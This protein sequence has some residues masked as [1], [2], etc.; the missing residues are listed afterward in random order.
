MVNI[1]FDILI[2]SGGKDDVDE[3]LTSE[4]I[5]LSFSHLIQI[6]DTIT[7]FR[8]MVFKDTFNNISVIS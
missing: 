1:Y 5:F 2:Y 8:V 7:I 3:I 4:S 6:L